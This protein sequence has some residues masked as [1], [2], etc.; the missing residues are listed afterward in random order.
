[1]ANPQQQQHQQHT[2]AMPNHTPGG[3]AVPRQLMP[4]R[5]QPQQ[6]RERQWYDK[7]VDALV[8]EEGPETKYA[9][10]CRHCFMHNGLVLPQEIDYIRKFKFQHII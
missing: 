7:L 6:P 5:Q 10:I 2:G 1:M 9:L 8:G 4:Q 3:L